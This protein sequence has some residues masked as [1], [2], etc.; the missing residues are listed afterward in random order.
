MPTNS[1]TAKVYE[2]TGKEDRDLRRQGGENAFARSLGE[3]PA[4]KE[5]GG[6]TY[7]APHE[8]KDEPEKE[9]GRGGLAGE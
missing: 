1:D 4:K 9:V 5:R 8:K 2:D 6:V 3:P 7:T